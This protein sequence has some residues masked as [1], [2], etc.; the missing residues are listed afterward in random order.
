MLDTAFIP[1]KVKSSV[2]GYIIVIASEKSITNFDIVSIETASAIIA[3][4]S[5]RRISIQ[6]VE[7]RYK[8]EFFEDLISFDKIRKNKAIERALYYN[9]DKQALYNIVLLYI[10]LKET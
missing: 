5:L 1:I 8:A 3:V 6:E 2:Y 7:N 9:F 4:E 10:F